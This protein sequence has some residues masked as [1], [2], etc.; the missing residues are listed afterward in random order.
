[1]S[2]CILSRGS[3]AL[4]SVGVI[5]VGVLVLLIGSCGTL[6]EGQLVWIG[7]G[8]SGTVAEPMAIQAKF[9]LPFVQAHYAGVLVYRSILPGI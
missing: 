5:A 3:A 2:K 7:L 4:L 8:T 1:M 9:P 6:P